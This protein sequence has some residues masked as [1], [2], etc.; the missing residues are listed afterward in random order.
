[1]HSDTNIINK[2]GLN[3]DVVVINQTDV[4]EEV[5]EKLSNNC[6][7]ISTPERGLS[8]SRNMAI[9]N[10]NAEI[11]VLSDDDET[12]YPETQKEI[13]RAYY[14]HPEA[15]LLIFKV[16]NRN[17]KNSGE[18]HK[19]KFYELFRVSSHEISFRRQS[20][21]SKK[22]KFDENMGSGTGNGGGEENKFLLE[23]Y[24]K[25][26]NIYYYP[27]EI[28]S[29]VP[30]G[31][32]DSQWFHGF[33]PEYFFQRGYSTRYMLGLPLSVFYAIYYAYSHKNEFC[34]EITPQ[35]ALK[36]MLIGIKNDKINKNVRK[37]REK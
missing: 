8:K 2:T 35:E 6:L 13:E 34:N 12:F 36:Y 3:H 9:A 1:M 23:C 31:L 37:R 10:A 14:K 15:D 11:C 20:V 4:K 29:V 7:F 17:S 25:H 30:R 28:S 22:I 18:Y 32:S 24:K 19:L 21:T 33:T 5:R 16:K 27:L 26:L